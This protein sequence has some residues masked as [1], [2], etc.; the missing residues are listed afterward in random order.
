[1]TA[2]IN[3]IN[4]PS[5]Q[6]ALAVFI[7]K[8][9]DKG[10]LLKKVKEKEAATIKVHFNPE[11]L[12]ITC[13]NT[14]KKGK[15]KGAAKVVVSDKSAKLSMELIFDTTM[16]SESAG[17][18]STMAGKDVRIETNKIVRLMDPTQKTP[19]TKNAKEPKLPLIVIFQWGT[20]RFEG[21]IDSYREKLEL[22]SSEGVP[23]RATVSI[24]ITQQQRSFV[25]SQG[26]KGGKSNATGADVLPQ[27]NSPVKRLG[28]NKPVKNVIKDRGKAKDV[29]RLAKQNGIEDL[30][31]PDVDKLVV[32]DNLQRM[33]PKII[34]GDQMM[35]C[36]SFTRPLG[37]TEKLFGG[38][39][40]Q[41]DPA[42]S[43]TPRTKLS[44]DVGDL[45]TKNV[46]IGSN[47]IFGLG[48]EVDV[49]GSA[50]ISA[51]VGI[52]ADIELGIQF[53]E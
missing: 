42:V 19:R 46:S 30:R 5:S 3:N 51:D 11:T 22:F 17:A 1:M 21:Y 45:Y 47:T 40:N 7:P 50:S 4:K 10:R 25:P 15:G 39:R 2:K 9:D 28:Q 33:A 35:R 29:K 37:G 14:I 44:E 13:S 27:S 20:I 18:G 24:S 31:H 38:L 12:D 43:L 8:T 36:D 6:H 53:E 34:T 32:S 23:L 16:P 26:V 41:I 48:G 49:S 52:N